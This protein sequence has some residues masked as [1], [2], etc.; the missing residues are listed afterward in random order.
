MVVLPELIDGRRW[1]YIMQGIE[2]GAPSLRLLRHGGP[3]PTMVLV[4]W[5]LQASSPGNGLAEEDY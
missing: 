4:P 1:A 2:N 3:R 5:Q